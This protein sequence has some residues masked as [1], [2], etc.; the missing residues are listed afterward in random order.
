MQAPS[1]HV[2]PALQSDSKMQPWAKAGVEV[3]QRIVITTRLRI[4]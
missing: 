4:A 2:V 3:R 1:T